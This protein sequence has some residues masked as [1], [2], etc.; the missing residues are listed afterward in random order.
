MCSLSDMEIHEALSSW[1]PRNAT[2]AQIRAAFTKVHNVL[3][4]NTS[5]PPS[6]ALK[7]LKD[8]FGDGALK[9]SQ[10]RIVPHVVHL[11][12]SGR[13]IEPKS[14]FSWRRLQEQ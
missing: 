11:M 10:T 7:Y 1:N 6:K 13:I 14:I 12:T 4:T 5:L 9:T 3:A 2:V 8:I